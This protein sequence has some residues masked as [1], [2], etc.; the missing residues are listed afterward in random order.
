MFA[1][2]GN[3]VIYLKRISIGK[4]ELDKKLPPGGYRKLGGDELELLF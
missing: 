3:R 2:A 1:A 4:L